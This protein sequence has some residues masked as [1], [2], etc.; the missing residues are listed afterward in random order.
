MSSAST[1]AEP[2]SQL[3]P[4]VRWRRFVSIY[5]RTVLTEAQ[6]PTS[7]VQVRTSAR[8]S[9]VR[10]MAFSFTSGKR[11]EGRLHNLVA[12]IPLPSR[13][14]SRPTWRRSQVA[15]RWDGAQR[16]ELQPETPRS[17]PAS[18]YTS[19]LT[20][21]LSTMERCHDPIRLVSFGLKP[22][23]CPVSTLARR[24]ESPGRHVGHGLYPAAGLAIRLPPLDAPA[25]AVENRQ[26]FLRLAAYVGRLLGVPSGSGGIGESACRL[27]HAATT[28]GAPPPLVRLCRPVGQVC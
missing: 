4:R 14:R 22:V 10:T 18:L 27:V 25:A 11:S 16:Q 6:H 23:L 13:M 2:V 12:E 7:G 9:A 15:Q 20:I 5:E 1:T 8:P 26:H 19:H 21:G 3:Q 28:A 24:A 17:I